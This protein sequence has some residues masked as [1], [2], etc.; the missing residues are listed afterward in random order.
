MKLHHLRDLLAVVDRGSIRAAAKQLG[1]G[2]PAL[3]RSIRDLEQEIGVPLLERHAKGT[4]LTPLGE[5]FAAR[6]RAAVGELRKA[7]EEI[8]Q[9]QGAVHGTVVVCLSSLSHITLLP[10]VLRPFRQRFPLV[11]LRL[12]EGVY[13]VVESRLRDGTIDFYVGPEAATVAPGLSQKVLFTNSRIVLARKGHPLAN[14]RSLK[15]LI[16]ADWI[17]TSITERAES[18]FNELFGQYGLPPPRLMMTA[19]SALT[20]ITAVAYSDTLA[21]SPRQWANSSLL[22]DLLVQIPIKEALSS[23]PVVTIRRAALP[24]TPAVEYFADLIARAGRHT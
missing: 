17:T 12:I 14:A 15:E 18:E 21:I 10:D 20:W 5:L 23:P 3:S 1:L 24:L 8:E 6:A 11:H 16:H 22:R 19:E 7:Q 13:P 2:Q 9:H 4:V